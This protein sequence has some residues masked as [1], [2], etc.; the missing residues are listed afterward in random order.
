MN[1]Y[2]LKLEE[3]KEDGWVE[4]SA[5]SFEG[6]VEMGASGAASGTNMGYGLTGKDVGADFE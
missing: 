3:I 2:G 4:D 1:L 5:I 6:Y